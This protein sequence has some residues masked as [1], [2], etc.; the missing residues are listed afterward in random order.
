MK[1]KLGKPLK[2]F[3]LLCMALSLAG[4]LQSVMAATQ[5]DNEYISAPMNG[6]AYG[7][8]ISTFVVPPTPPTNS[9]QFI[10]LW[11]AINGEN[12]VL[13]PTLN[14]QTATNSWRI[15]SWN[16]CDIGN[17]T[18]ESATLNVSPGDVILGAILP[19]CAVGVT[20]CQNWKISQTNL[21]AG[22]SVT[23]ATSIKN[24]SLTDI[25][26]AFLE[27]QYLSRCSDLPGNTGVTFT[28]YAFDSGLNLLT[29]AWS[30]GLYAHNSANGKAVPPLACGYSQTTSGAWHTLG[31]NSGAAATPGILMS[32]S[33]A[34]ASLQQGGSINVTVVL[35]GQN[36]F[37][38]SSTLSAY[39]LPAGVTAV[40]GTN[41]ATSQSIV[42]L[43][44]SASAAL[45][46]VPIAIIGNGTLNGRA[47]RGAVPLLLTVGTS[48]G[49][50]GL[51]LCSGTAVALPSLATGGVSANYTLTVPAGKTS[52]VFTISGGTGDAD[53]YVRQ[54]SAPTSA[55]YDCRPYLNG[56]SETCTFNAPAA[57]TYHV[58]VRAYTTYSGV[59]LKGTISP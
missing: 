21:T 54:A 25:Y 53:L 13:Q 49:C 22:G 14:Y 36:G 35:S 4:G 45:G 32:S 24:Q 42:T 39:G 19:Q 3:S 44:A 52:A 43:T 55:T 20:N 51:V 59:S 7:P 38:G 37:N 31:Y 17:P 1:K 29:P 58:N 30:G 33:S 50:S 47:V 27:T 10:S 18:D 56:N 46:T 41:P 8:I 15:Q 6:A 16:C 28:S 57:G 11:P 9:G 48:G 5:N 2:V 34:K 40:F 26:P 12:S 23:L